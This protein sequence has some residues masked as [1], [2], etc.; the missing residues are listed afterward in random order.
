MKNWAAMDRFCCGMNI[1]ID[2]KARTADLLFRYETVVREEE[3]PSSCH[4]IL[5]HN[6]NVNSRAR[7]AKIG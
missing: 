5:L 7:I 1:A 2:T 3:P 4:A 6:P